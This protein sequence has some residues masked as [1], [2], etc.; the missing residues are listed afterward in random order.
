MKSKRQFLKIVLFRGIIFNFIL[1]TCLEA[2]VFAA[3]DKKEE[4][5]DSFTLGEWAYSRLS[6]AYNF[7][8]EKKY[9]EAIEVLDIIKNRKRVNDHERAIMWQTYGFIWSS[10]ENF[11]KAISAFEKCLALNALPKGAMTEIEFNL[12]QLY[13]ANKRYKKGA[14]ILASWIE[15]VENPTPDS[16][17]LLAMAY[18]Q[19]LQ[20]KHALLWAKKAIAR[21]KQPKESW[22]QFILSLHFQLKQFYEVARTLEILVS[23]YSKKSYWLQ[24]AAIYGQLKKE[25]ASLAVLELAY[26]KNFL[27][28]ESELMNLASLYLHRGIPYKAARVLEKGIA[29]GMIERNVKSLRMQAQSWLHARENKRAMAPL[30]SAAELHDNGDLYVQIAQIHISWEEW[31]KASKTLNQAIK[32]GN[33]ANPGIT[34]VLLGITRHNLSQYQAALNALDKAR[35]HSKTEKTAVKWIKIVKHKLAEIK[36][37]QE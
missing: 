9:K 35:Q 12:G 22:Y 14:S 34:Y 1:L 18:A 27:T 33:L 31:K 10:K 19:S 6:K 13:I 32:K 8:S 20:N 36:M 30:A 17:Y 25:S 24:L 15:K 11:K 28:K 4:K 23:R 16:Q 26:T 5:E 2:S 3:D 29:S 21:V 7:L 37:A